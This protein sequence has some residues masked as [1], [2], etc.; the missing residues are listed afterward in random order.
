[1][2]QVAGSVDPAT[3]HWPSKRYEMLVWHGKP[4]SIVWLLFSISHSWELSN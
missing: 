1:M 2:L 4:G 3:D